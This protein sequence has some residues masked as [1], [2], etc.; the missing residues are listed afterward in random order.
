M[1]D[2]KIE[3]ALRRLRKFII[4]FR[5][6]SRGSLARFKG[7]IEHRR[8]T[9]GTGNAVLELMLRDKILSYRDSMYFLDA[10]NLAAHTGLSYIDCMECQFGAQAIVFVRRAI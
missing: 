10:D 2:P 8:M 5:S 9:K 6:H 3:E 1:D 7:K 4:S